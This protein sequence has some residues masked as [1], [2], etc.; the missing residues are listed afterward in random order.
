MAKIDCIHP[1]DRVIAVVEGGLDVAV[2]LECEFQ[3]TPSTDAKMAFEVLYGEAWRNIAEKRFLG[4]VCYHLGK[5]KKVDTP[6]GFVAVCCDCGFKG[7][8][9]FGWGIAL[10]SLHAD[11][12]RELNGMPR[13]RKDEGHVRQL[14]QRTDRKELPGV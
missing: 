5:V 13:K 8:P 9:Y 1:E 12:W 4:D 11:A 10:E 14:R 3:G 2:C 7:T 6:D